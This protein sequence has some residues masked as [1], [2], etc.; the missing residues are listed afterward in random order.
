MKG[1]GGPPMKFQRLRVKY[2]FMGEDHQHQH[3]HHHS[4]PVE[5]WRDSDLPFGKKL[6]VALGNTWIKISKRQQCC[7][8][9]GDPGC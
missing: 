5:N 4:A 8:H 7:G 2:F 3:D 6:K 1:A 9:P